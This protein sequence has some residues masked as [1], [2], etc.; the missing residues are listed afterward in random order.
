MSECKEL[1]ELRAALG[2]A[3]AVCKALCFGVD[4]H[5]TAGWLACTV[6][7]CYSRGNGHNGFDARFKATAAALEA[8]A[9][10]KPAPAQPKCAKCGADYTPLRGDAMCPVCFGNYQR[11]MAEA[12][13]VEVLRERLK[14]GVPIMVG[15]MAGLVTSLPAGQTVRCRVSNGNEGTCNISDVTLLVPETKAPDVQ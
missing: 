10:G 5:S 12:A 4:A 2:R 1:A 9:A 8:W 3:E 15:E 6:A 14:P 11:D 7:D 13:R